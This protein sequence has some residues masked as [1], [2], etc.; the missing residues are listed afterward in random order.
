MN[1]IIISTSLN[2]NSHSRL[3]AQEM[4]KRIIIQNHT[5]DFIDLQAYELPIC[6]SEDCYN[7]INV[8]NI[9]PRIQQ[10]DGILIAVPIYNYNVAASAKNLLELTGSAWSQ[11]VVGLLCAAGGEMSYM[12]ALPF[13]GGLLFDFRC[14]IVPRYVYASKSNFSDDHIK[15]T[16]PKIHE[17]L[18]ALT[19]EFTSLS[20]A[21]HGQLNN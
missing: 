5:I 4:Q 21:L 9:T 7:H 20:N 2:P 16:N 12:S 18:D 8:Q 17:R 6:G 1:Y 10:A 19:H 14:I 13:I 3:L 15:I 11:K